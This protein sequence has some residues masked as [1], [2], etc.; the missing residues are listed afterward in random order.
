MEA[1]PLQFEVENHDDIVSIAHRMNGRFDL[2]EESSK[3]FAIGLKL[4]GEV[5]LKNRNRE[6]FSLIDRRLQSL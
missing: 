3:A 4:F 1:D 2:G 5:L 6:P